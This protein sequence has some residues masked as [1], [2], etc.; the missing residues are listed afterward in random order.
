[1]GFRW[2]N[3]VCG[4]I[5]IA[6][7]SWVGWRFTLAEETRTLGWVLWGSAILGTS[8]IGGW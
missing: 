3:L 2:G 6:A 5:W 8:L 7:F 4:F 1:M